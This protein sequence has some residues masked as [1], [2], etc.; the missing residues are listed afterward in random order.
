[1]RTRNYLWAVL[2]A[3]T[4]SLAACG[5]EENENTEPQP[6]GKT[7]KL[8]IR[9]QGTSS[10]NTKSTGT[11][12][13]IGDENK[14]QRIAVAIFNSTGSVNTISESTNIAANNKISMNCTPG[15]GCSGVAVANAP[16]NAF[17]GITTKNAFLA[18]TVTLGQ[19]ATELPMSG[20]I[21]DNTTSANT[22]T[23]TAGNTTSVKVDLTRMV[24]RV[25][26]SSI[27]TAFDPAGQYSKATFTAKQIFMH[28]AKTTSNVDPGTLTTT[29]LKT[30]WDDAS[31]TADHVVAL[32]DVISGGGVAITGTA[33]TT[34]YWFYTFPNDNTTSTRLVIRGDFDPDGSGT[35]TASDVYYPVVVN[36][37]Q[38]GTS[39]NSGAKD[40]TI[41]RN[42]TYAITATIKG[43]GAPN[44]NTNMA[45]A[46]L[47]LTVTVA[48]WALNIT[49]DVEF[50]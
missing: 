12:P 35:V 6:Q 37:A 40:G 34:P 23:L 20:E 9:V 13:G 42:T 31:V 19:T 18:K 25:S 16:A 3:A 50:N 32:K 11:L 15:A 22:F 21:K 14:I 5:G 46:T 45:P 41:A 17:A 38:T 24:A 7:T 1:M 49:Q 47:D 8:E 30:G 39:I 10:S 33:Y 43:K 29:S 26:V 36:L 4:L 28:N 2:A 44:P 27:K 48:A